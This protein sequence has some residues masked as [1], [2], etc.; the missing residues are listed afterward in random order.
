MMAGAQVP[1]H[2]R[3]HKYVDRRLF[4]DLLAHYERWR[5]LDNFV[6]LS[7]G[8]YPLE[9]HRQIHRHL[10]ITR[11]ISFDG[12]EN[13]VKRQK[14][15]LPVGSC[16]CLNRMSSE[17]VDKIDDILEDGGASDATGVIIWLD[18]TDPKSLG[19]QIR[20]FQTLLDKLKENDIIRVTVNAHPGSLGEPKRSD[21]SHYVKQELEQ[22]RYNNLRD[23]IG[24][25]L[26]S[27]AS[28]ADMGRDEYPKLLA[29]AF[30]QAALNAL[31][32]AGRKTCVPLSIMSYADGQQMLSITTAIV[33]RDCVGEMKTKIGMNVWPF[34][35]NDWSQVHK[36]RVP[37]LT[38]RERL[39]IDRE[40]MSSDDVTIAGK[41]GFEVDDNY[42]FVEFLGDYRN[43][44]RFYPSLVPAEY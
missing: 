24:D 8:A 28:P 43:Y 9:D 7:M 15:N 25:Y 16:V 18:Y 44:Y 37:A 36:L 14:F 13:V 29:Q 32:V 42:P 23:R 40:L 17:V 39:F 1:Y 30:G 5:A 12:D 22:I 31:P 35:V 26:P 3:P 21:G 4:L 27:S 2:L 33:A 10:G 6:Y 34:A 38:Y 20:E 11:L 19:Q 41:L